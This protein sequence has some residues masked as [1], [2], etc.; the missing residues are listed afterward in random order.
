MAPGRV[1]VRLLYEG[2]DTKDLE[3]VEP[4]PEAVFRPTEI[5][6]PFSLPS[7]AP[8]TEYSLYL[9]R[10]SIPRETVPPV[11]RQDPGFASAATARQER[12]SRCDE[13]A[14][15]LYMLPAQGDSS[16][17]AAHRLCELCY[18]DK[19]AERRKRG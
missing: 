14:A 2:G 4:L 17:L 7:G 3:L 6:D 18:L 9:F 16:A 11:Y 13:K 8:P 5:I 1:T 15:T 10:R 19:Q 12:C